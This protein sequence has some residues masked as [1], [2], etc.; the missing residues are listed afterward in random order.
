[1]LVALLGDIV[2]VKSTLEPTLID[3]SVVSNE[4]P[5]TA[6][7][8]ALTVTLQVAVL[9][10][11]LVVTVIIL[12]PSLTAVT[13]PLTTVQFPLLELQV[14]CLFVAL[15]GIIDEPS[16]PCDYNGSDISVFHKGLCI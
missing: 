16:N 6:T 8:T 10:P 1:M 12:V 4:T 5:V 15:E 2:A 14:T 7:T 13:K 3:A 9:F 11:S